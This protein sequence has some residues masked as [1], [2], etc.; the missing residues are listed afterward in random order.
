[1][2]EFKVG[3]KVQ[4]VRKVIPPGWRNTWVPQMDTYVGDGKLYLVSYVGGGRG[5]TL[6]LVNGQFCYTFPEESLEL[7]PVTNLIVPE[8]E[9][10]VDALVEQRRLL[11]QFLGV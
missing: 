11:K 8:G 2:S 1:M 4:I 5:V 3:D 10:S 9:E 6:Q 7:A